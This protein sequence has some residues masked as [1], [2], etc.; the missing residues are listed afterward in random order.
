MSELQIQLLGELALWRGDRR[1]SLPPSKKTRA[2]LAYLVLTNRPHRRE[3]LCEMFWELPDDPRGAL[4]WSLS[5]LR[6]VVNI[7]DSENLA[8]DR[9]RVVWNMGDAQVDRLQLNH[10]LEAGL[11]APNELKHWALALREPLLDGLDLPDQSLYQQWLSAERLEAEHLAAL[12]A[13]RLCMH[14][15]TTPRE[16]VEHASRWLNLEPIEPDACMVLLSAL[17]A[18]GHDS[19]ARKQERQLRQRLHE[20]GVSWPSLS[21]SVAAPEPEL[22]APAALPSTSLSPERQL[23]ARQKITFCSAA[24]GTRIAY[25]RVGEGPALVKAANWLNHLELDW[26]API[27]SPLF[28]QLARDFELIRYDERGNGLSDWEVETISPAVFTTDLE[29]VVDAAGLE[30]FALMGISQGASV[31]IDYAV[32]H[33]DRVTHLILFG[34]YAAGWRVDADEAQI[35]EREAIMTLTATGWGRDNPAYRQIFSSTF[36]PSAT[37]EELQWFNDFQRQ[38]TTPENAVRFLSAFGD[39]D[40]RDKLAEV[41]VPTLV[42]HSRGDK[43]IPLHSAREIASA[44]PGA[45]FLS[46]DSDSHLLLGREPASRV[47]IDAVREFIGR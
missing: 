31:S 32:H 47:F 4:R 1:L 33:P 3:R 2:L 10:R 16:V 30:R 11:D 34:G 26:D 39:I 9:E 6:A 13:R 28:Q 18:V 5:K 24:D 7:D 43:R 27:W 42:I 37:P 25:A 21:G 20:A 35:K 22:A 38:T 8:A 44:I 40:V 17:R 45:E 14:P 36:M 46:L 19:E 23:L 29:T 41:S 15:E 12:V